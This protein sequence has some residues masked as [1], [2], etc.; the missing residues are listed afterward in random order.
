MPRKLKTPCSHPSCP[1]LVEAGER[2]CEKHRKAH[3]KQQD[4]D[5]GS[6]SE[7]GYGARWRRARAYFLKRN[8]LCVE[9]LRG[10]Q[11]TAA[12]VVDHIVPHKGNY[13]LFWDSENNWQALCEACH[14]RKTANET[15]HQK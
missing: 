11:T 2:F 1:A 7:R 10:G 9:C 6:A 4:R 14:N 13:G 3:Y 8:V 5:R 12:T 15:F